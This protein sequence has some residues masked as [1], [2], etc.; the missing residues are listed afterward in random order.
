MY[1]NLQESGQS[2]VLLADFMAVLDKAS[3]PYLQAPRLAAY[4]DLTWRVIF[5]VKWKL[6]LCSIDL[7]T[8]H[9]WHS[10]SVYL[11]AFF[12][13]VIAPFYKT[14]TCSG[15]Q[16]PSFMQYYSNP[17]RSVLMA[18]AIL[19][20]PPLSRSNTSKGI[21]SPQT[22]P[23]RV[24]HHPTP[25]DSMRSCRTDVPPAASGQRT[26]FAAAA[27]VE[28]VVG[29]MSVRRVPRLW[30]TAVSYVLYISMRDL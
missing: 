9:G 25:T 18:L 1:A 6:S 26:I 14:K 21:H 15:I 27:A 29:W 5:F 30:Y 20:F 28:D 2:V 22:A 10:F 16:F 23:I 4:P 3:L 11:S 17:V 12:V 19:H 7:V 13:A 8:W 24:K